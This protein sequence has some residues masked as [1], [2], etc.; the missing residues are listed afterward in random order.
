MNI[1]LY[2]PLGVGK[3][4]VGKTLAARLGREFVDSDPL[5]EARAGLTIPQVFAQQGEVAFR[6]FESTICNEL[7]ARNNLVIAPGG[8]AL[9][10]P[11]NRAALE[12]NGLI[13]CL[14]AAEDALLARMPH[15]DRPLLAGDAAA[16]LHALLEARQSLYDSFAVQLDTTR[17]SIP[18]VVDEIEALV[19]PRRLQITAPGFEHE[20]ALGY[21]L[22]ENLPALLTQR[23]LTGTTLIVTDENIKAALPFFNQSGNTPVVVLPAGEDHK[24]LA[25]IARLYD[26]FLAHGL[27]RNSIVIAV[28]GGVI[29]DM[30]GFAAATYMRGIKWVNVPTTL[31]SMV[32]ASLGGKTGVDLPQGKNLVGAF[33]PP[34]LIVSDPLTLQTLP[35][36]EWIG[37][38]A[39]VIKH[40]LIDDTSLF[41]WIEAGHAFGSVDVLQQAISVKVRVVNEDP[42]E[43]GRRALLNVGHTIGHAVESASGFKL[44]HGESVAIGMVAEAKLAKRL[45]VA[46]AG[47]P[48]RL[49]RVCA[50]VGLP[51]DARGMEPGHIRQLMSSDKKKAGK[52]LKFALPKRVGEAAYGIEAD[53]AVLMDTL[54]E[55][56]T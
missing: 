15:T 36:R 12:Q 1:V 26:A 7:A 52:Q 5:I 49:A 43:K 41:E 10:N 23:N 53:E 30:V 51:V 9:L 16:K 11:A 56:V 40:G 37:G 50:Q 24:N 22:L 38:M 17:K 32:D 28:G 3:S 14:R 19:A 48:E 34:S 45:E 27:D 47:L 35:R 33:Y 29:G 25:T 21:G 6:E 44:S 46:E 13:I 18:Q 4:T 54:N 2:G 42:Y 20:I 8:G 55:L 39:E 31:L